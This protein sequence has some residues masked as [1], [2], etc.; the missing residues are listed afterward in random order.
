MRLRLPSIF[1]HSRYNALGAEQCYRVP[2]NCRG[3]LGDHPIRRRRHYDH[4]ADKVEPSHHLVGELTRTDAILVR[5]VQ[6]LI[7]RCPPIWSAVSEN[8]TNSR[9]LSC[10]SGS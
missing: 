2:E 4:Q 8:S 6:M 1:D 9:L 3:P 5:L 10:I 7:A